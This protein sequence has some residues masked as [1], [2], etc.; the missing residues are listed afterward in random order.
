MLLGYARVSTDVQ[1][2]HLQI[3]ALTG[4]G[5]DRIYQEKTSGAK[6]DRPELR[7]AAFSRLCIRLL[8]RL[9]ASRSS[10]YASHSA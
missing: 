5:V 4:A 7:Q 10:S 8:L 3:D 9:A 6:T 1:E 2:T